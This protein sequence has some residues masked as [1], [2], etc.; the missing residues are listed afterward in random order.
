LFYNWIKF[1]II[2]LQRNNITLKKKSEQ[3]Y[4]LQSELATLKAHNEELEENLN[5]TKLELDAITKVTV[6]YLFIII[7]L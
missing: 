7:I 4:L 6:L 5:S 2:F 1:F 3:N